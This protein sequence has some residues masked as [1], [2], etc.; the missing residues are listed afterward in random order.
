MIC[1]QEEFI[2][3]SICPQEESHNDLRRKV[4]MASGGSHNIISS[5]GKS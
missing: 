5:R 4:I 1:P 3:I 2:M